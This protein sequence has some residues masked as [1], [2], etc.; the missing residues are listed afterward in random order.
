VRILVTLVT[1]VVL[2]SGAVTVVAEPVWSPRP[3]TWG[4]CTDFPDGECGTLRV[5][6]DWRRPSGATV[7]LAVARHL[8]TD[9]AHRL[10]VL[11]VNPGGPGT[12]N[13]EFALTPN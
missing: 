13:A 3:I 4:P 5:P 9:R 8:A 11:L 12:S 6:L 2:L 10:G 1:S 7:D